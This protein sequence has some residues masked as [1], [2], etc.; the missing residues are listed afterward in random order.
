LLIALVA[1]G[2]TYLQALRTHDAGQAPRVTSSLVTARSI[3]VLP[4]RNLGSHR[5]DDYLSAMITDD[6]LR[7][8]R[9]V[10]SLNV[11]PFRVDVEQ[12][13]QLRPAD[14]SAR[15]GVDLALDG[16]F[17]REGNVLHVRARLWDTKSGKATW[18][19]SFDAP[20]ADTREMRSGIATALVTQ[21]QIQ[22][23]SDLRAQLQTDALT[24]SPAAYSN[25]LRARYLLRWRR[26]ETLIEAARLLR[27]AIALD[28]GFA[29][30]H[31]ALA[32]VYALWI[33]PAPPEGDPAQLAVLQARSA[34]GR[35]ASLGEPHAVLGNYHSSIGMPIDAEVDF[36]QAL[37]LDPRDPAALHFYAIHLYSMGRLKEA[38]EMERRSVAND[39]S[40]PQPMMWLA[41]ATTLTG[42]AE[43]AR[44]LWQKADELGA[45]RPLCAAIARLDLGQQDHLAE[46][47]RSHGGDWFH[48]PPGARVPANLLDTTT[49][50]AGVLDP[51][52]RAPAL[53]W[54]RRVEP[55]ADKAFL[56]TH[57][58]LLGDADGAF[59]VAE[60][61]SPVEDKRLLYRLCNIWS[62][63][64][65]S[66]RA[67]PRFG[68]LVKRWGFVDYWQRFGAPESCTI[69]NGAARCR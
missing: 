46:W 51:A 15:L 21:L 63:R 5:D 54:L 62:P 11:V 7:E 58:G 29:Q 10:A 16:D 33:S 45:A 55:H 69:T 24:S 42:D 50:A 61:F 67:D 41:M 14:L 8:L 48:A 31:S 36:R 19:K 44:R 23:G 20:A 40:S 6:L 60:S 59:R 49:L 30:A 17:T 32:Y 27:E 65:A 1:G 37:Q 28:D 4:L 12:P 3:A 25:Y 56:I 26:D 47:Y 57:F 2:G 18:Q 68:G 22:V 35:D 53:E 13:D 64:T 52:R 9:Q 34:I 39:G 66:I 38:L 43:E